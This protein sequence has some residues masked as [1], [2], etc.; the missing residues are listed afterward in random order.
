MTIFLRALMV[1]AMAALLASAGTALAQVSPAAVDGGA[2]SSP[3]RPFGLL[4]RLFGGEEQPPAPGPRSV[5]QANGDLVFRLDRLEAQIRQLTGLVEQ[6]Q[7]R[8]QQL[9]AQVRR[10]QEDTEYRLQEL[11]GKGSPRPPVNSRSTTAS[12]VSPTAPVVPTTPGRRSDVFD[13]TQNPNAPG[14]PRTLGSIPTDPSATGPAPE[15]AAE[16]PPP[17]VPGGRFAGTPLDLS[18]LA[19]PLHDPAV[20][21]PGSIDQGPPPRPPRN[22]EGANPQVAT[23]PPAD[24]PRDQ[25]DLSYGFVLRKDYGQ[26]EEGFRIFL[27]KYP[28]DRLAPDAQYWLGESLYQRQ[29]WRDAAEFFLNVSTKYETTAKAPDALLRLGQSL[30]ALGEKEAACA[31]F[32]EVSRKYPARLGRC[33]ARR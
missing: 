26:A 2:Q 8:N 16:E 30:A 27:K 24:T 6:L 20:V 23:L 13:P 28:N 25:Y 21:P 31:S 19:G 12:P 15:V 33:E 3:D 10:S 4:D 29:H 22:P 18:T 1:P 9:E 14:A 7:Y 32:G 17:Q 5:A 11:G